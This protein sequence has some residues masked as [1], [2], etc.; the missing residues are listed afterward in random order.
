MWQ[1]PVTFISASIPYPLQ[2][3]ATIANIFYEPRM[4]IQ[5]LTMYTVI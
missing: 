3:E 1:A 2:L 5:M 4:D